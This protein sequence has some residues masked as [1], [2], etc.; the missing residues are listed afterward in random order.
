[1]FFLIPKLEPAEV[2][3][4][5]KIEELRKS[6]GYTVG[7]PKRWTGLL[8]R[9]AFAKAIRSSNSIEGINATVEDAMAAVNGEEPTDADL[10]TWRAITGY[11]N[12]MTYVLQ[13]AKD[14]HFSFS[15]DLI[16]SL[17]YMMIGHEL[18]KHPGTWRPGQIFVRDEEKGSVVYE[19]P[20]VEMVPDLMDEL[21]VSLQS[22]MGGHEI[23]R[24]AMAHLNLVMIHPF[25]DGNGRMARCLQTLVLAREGV[26]APQFSSIEEE[27]GRHTRDYY[28]VLAET[29]GG[30]WQPQRD[31]R[32]WIRFVLRA[33]YRQVRRALARVREMQRLWSALEEEAKKR[34]L[35]ERTV[36]ALVEAAMGFR[37]RNSGYRSV[38]E[39]SQN[40]ASRDLA[41]L[42]QHGLLIPVGEKRGRSY[43]ASEE[44]LKIR[45]TTREPRIID[46]P[47]KGTEGLGPT[48]LPSGQ[49]PLFRQ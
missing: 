31:T 47:F 37:I 17:H 9:V 38:A 43:S 3:V 25:S 15:T 29:G 11:R 26:L 14:P 49:Q 20:P 5:A 21:S 2:E 35:P 16:R 23:I 36:V 24:A 41:L 42:V 39:V 4:L 48:I 33:H 40:L 18:E 12:A 30:T 27:V 19:G 22:E 8:R 7:E 6:L 10:D 13:L 44:V 1:M 28:D 46:D 32:S 34:W 45:K